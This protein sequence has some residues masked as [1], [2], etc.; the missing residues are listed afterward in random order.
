MAERTGE[1]RNSA[2]PAVGASCLCSAQPCLHPGRRRLTVCSSVERLG[3]LAPGLYEPLQEDPPGKRDV[4]VGVEHREPRRDRPHGRV[5]VRQQQLGRRP[6]V[7]DT[8]G[9]NSSV[10]PRLSGDPRDHLTPSRISSEEK[11]QGLVRR[12]HPTRAHR[13]PPTRSRRRGTPF[14]SSRTGACSSL[15]GSRRAASGTASNAGTASGAGS[16]EPDLAH[17]RAPADRDRRRSSPRRAWSGRRRNGR[18]ATA[19]TA[20]MST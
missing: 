15:Q 3:A 8:G 18:D 20:Q 10:R 19:E 7:R 13:R 1:R 17:D 16:S 12:T 4:Q 9:A 6:V 11:A 5:S 2:A 14:W